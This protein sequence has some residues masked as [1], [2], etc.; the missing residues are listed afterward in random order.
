MV[1]ITLPRLNKILA[2]A[3]TVA[4]EREKILLI[5]VIIK[6]KG[7][8]KIK[9]INEVITLKNIEKWANFLLS[10]LLENSVR[11]ASKLVPILAPKINGRAS[12]IVIIFVFDSIWRIVIN[13]LEDWRTAVNKT[14]IIKL[15]KEFSVAFLIYKIKREFSFND[16][17]EKESKNIEKNNKD[18]KKMVVDIDDIFL[19]FDFVNNKEISI[20]MGAIFSIFI[21]INI[22]ESVVAILLPK[23]IPILWLNERIFAFISV[24]VNKIIA[25]LDWV[26]S[27]EQKPVIKAFLSEEVSVSILGFILG[28]EAEIKDFEIASRE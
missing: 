25:E 6:E 7:V 26:I 10:L 18:I 12:M 11:S 27:V 20:I 16:D 5:R 9:N 21:P 17:M 19:F 24:I 13:K 28:I 22:E 8:R 4:L 15:K 2:I 3:I 23:T 14:P 1:I